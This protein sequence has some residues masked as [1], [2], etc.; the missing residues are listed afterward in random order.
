[1][2]AAHEAEDVVQESL[3]RA[4]V[5]Q[6]AQPIDNLRAYLHRIARN[7]SVDL[8]RS[9]AVRERTS[10]GTLDNAEA[11]AVASQDVPADQVLIARQRKA[12]F[13]AALAALPPRQ[14]QALT[15]H[16]LEGWS[17][18]RIAAHL[19]C[20]TGTVF[21]EVKAAISRITSLTAELDL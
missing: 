3:L 8:H 1:M 18:P 7:L 13:E 2:P 6:Q 21:N 4:V 20:S 19:G 15:L 16:R 17:Y 10:G 12:A 14:R 5:V 11:L 9:R